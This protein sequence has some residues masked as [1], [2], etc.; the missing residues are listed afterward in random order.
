MQKY[1]LVYSKK[2]T[3]EFWSALTIDEERPGGWYRHQTA[4]FGPGEWIT[5]FETD[6]STRNTRGNPEFRQGDLVDYYEPADLKGEKV[7]S[8]PCIY[9]K[10]LKGRKDAEVLINGEVKKVWRY[11]L[12]PPKTT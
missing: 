12:C 3:K 2:S 7:F 5:V 4:W 9:M 10:T 8:S 6:L 1:I 11:R